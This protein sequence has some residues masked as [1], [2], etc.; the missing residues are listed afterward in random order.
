M[1]QRKQEALRAEMTAAIADYPAVAAALAELTR[2]KRYYE[3]KIAE[4]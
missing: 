1:L 2:A 3:F 4:D